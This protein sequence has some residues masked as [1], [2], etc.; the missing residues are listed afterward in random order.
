MQFLR[1]DFAKQVVSSLQLYF[2]HFL[3]YFVVISYQ[4]GDG[5]VDTEAKLQKIIAAVEAA[6]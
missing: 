4:N 3:T 2:V 5:Y 6:L 1:G